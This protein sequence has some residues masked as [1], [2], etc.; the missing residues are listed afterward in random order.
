M[1]ILLDESLAKRMFDLTCGTCKEHAGTFRLVPMDDTGTIMR[2]E[3]DMI[4]SH[5]KNSSEVPYGPFSFHT[6]NI[7]KGWTGGPNLSTDAPSWND[8]IIVAAYTRDHGLRYHFVFTPSY[9]YVMSAGQGVW[10]ERDSAENAYQSMLNRHGKN[11]GPAFLSEW[12]DSLRSYGFDVRQYPSGSGFEINDEF[13]AP[14]PAKSSWRTGSPSTDRARSLLLLLLLF[15]VVTL[16]FRRL[17]F[18]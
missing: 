2:L 5:D 16:I 18:F 8:A 14:L 7:P 11:F 4:T 12:V 10:L 17:F 15:F 3:V 9:T 13:G 1:K 6:H